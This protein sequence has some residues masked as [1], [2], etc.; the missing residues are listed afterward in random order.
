M[1]YTETPNNM[2]HNAKHTSSSIL[3]YRIGLDPIASFYLVG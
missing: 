2:L 3:S 1:G